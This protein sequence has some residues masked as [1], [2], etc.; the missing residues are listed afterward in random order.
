V[1][2]VAGLGYAIREGK[3]VMSHTPRGGQASDQATRGY[4]AGTGDSRQTNPHED[5]HA[6]HGVSASYESCLRPPAPSLNSGPDVPLEGDVNQDQ[7]SQHSHSASSL[8]RS[9][10]RRCRGRLTAEED[11]DCFSP[12]GALSIVRREDALHHRQRHWP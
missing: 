2:P 12:G 6:R 5:A 7:L 3:T 1:C 8:R 11:F 4:Q 9:G 10:V